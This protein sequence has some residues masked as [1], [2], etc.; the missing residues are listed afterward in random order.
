M[1]FICLVTDIGQAK[2]AAAITG[3]E[4]ISIVEG[5]V[6]DGGGS[7]TT[8]QS[9]DAGLV[10]ETSAR[11]AVNEISRTGNQVSVNFT[12]P[13]SDGGY[14]VREAAVWDEDGDMVL[15]CSV[16]AQEKPAGGET[17]QFN[18][19]ATLTATV[20]NG[21]VVQVTVDPLAV[22]ASRAYVQDYAGKVALKEGLAALE[23]SKTYTNDQLTSFAEGAAGVFGDTD[24]GLAGTVE[25]N[26]FNVPS[27]E[28]N[29]IYIVYRH[30]PGPAAFELGRTISA[31]VID[32]YFPK[33][34]SSRNQ[35]TVSGS[36]EDTIFSNSSG[37]EASAAGY[38]V[39]DY[40]PVIGGEVYNRSGG[41]SWG[42]WDAN[43][44]YLGQWQDNNGPV[45]VDAAY[46]RV[47]STTSS[48]PNIG[49]YAANYPPEPDTFSEQSVLNVDDMPTG[50]VAERH[51]TFADSL[52]NTNLYDQSAATPGK[53]VVSTGALGTYAPY[54]VSPFIPVK[55]STSYVMHELGAFAWYDSDQYFISYSAA[56]EV[57][58]SPSN[59]A[60]IRVNSSST[61]DEAKT[62][63]EATMPQFSP[64]PSNK[65]VA[66]PNLKVPRETTLANMAANGHLDP[67]IRVGGRHL[68]FLERRSP[69]LFDKTFAWRGALRSYA[70]GGVTVRDGLILLDE[71]STSFVHEVAVGGGE[72][73]RFSE[74][75]SWVQL[76]SNRN[77]LVYSTNQDKVVTTHADAAYFVNSARM[78]VIDSYMFCLESEFPEAY[79]PYDKFVI[80]ERVKHKNPWQG[81]KIV[82]MGTSIPAGAAYPQEIGDRLDAKMENIAL[83]GGNIV[84]FRPDGSMWSQ[85]LMPY[86]FTLEA[87]DV[88]SWAGANLGEEVDPDDYS[89][90]QPGSGVVLDQSMLDDLVARNYVNR[91]AP[92][93]D[94]DLFVFDYGIN[95]R[96][97]LGVLS[98]DSGY[99]RSTFTGAVKYLWK[100]IYDYKSAQGQTFQAVM[101]THHNRNLGLGAQNTTNQCVNEQLD[102]AEYLGMPVINVADNCGINSVNLQDYSDGL[103][104]PKDGILYHRVV[105][106]ST[107]RLRSIGL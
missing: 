70:V 51:T 97:N 102:V 52:Y 60:F 19:N 34:R 3:G 81:K 100:K 33:V 7:A 42:Q 23:S 76:D 88:Q 10:N 85:G 25:G 73:Y 82:W 18:F 8:P 78:A 24:A 57:A 28:P 37:A 11:F 87:A 94:A 104:F 26:Y 35:F 61:A 44:D 21:D 27:P 92:H 55:P 14:V 77:V 99:D 47:Y 63:S 93:Y 80:P 106:L 59:A 15:V 12:V 20:Q 48:F 98:Q 32:T 9:S 30:D 1:A 95:D 31:G 79:V 16:P 72:T 65:Q 29:E 17:G 68:D 69:N 39:S 75:L 6:G 105:E 22:N 91:L 90:L 43:K 45:H 56:A 84:A 5:A 107:D 96:E 41:T 40:L 50:F 38:V 13:A 89:T 64:S 74:T 86:L 62:L 101:V 53:Y 54:E 36:K 4:T 66:I 58:T 49:L 67:D 83:G 46:L 103:H 71:N 2:I